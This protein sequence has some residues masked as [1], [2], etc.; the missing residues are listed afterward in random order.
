MTDRDWTVA[1]GDILREWREQQHL[2]AETTAVLCFI[3]DD[4]YTR[5]EAGT[6]P[7]STRDACCLALGTGIS[8]S[9]WLALEHVYCDDLKAGR[10]RTP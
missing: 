7:L 1:P 6:E 4:R 2:T 8:A 9:L 5:I 10:K 3:D